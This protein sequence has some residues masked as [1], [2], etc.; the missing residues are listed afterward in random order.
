MAFLRMAYF[1]EATSEHFE[2]LVRQVP[3]EVP[4]GRLVFA[5]GQ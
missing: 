2:Q 3:P 4:A 5:P 1:P